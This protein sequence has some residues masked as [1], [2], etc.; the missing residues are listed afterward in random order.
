MLRD[1]AG[2]RVPCERVNKEVPILQKLLKLWNWAPRLVP[3]FGHAR[4]AQNW[5]ICTAAWGCRGI[6]KDSGGPN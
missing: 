2:A 1:K 5:I 6:V 4:V 3:S